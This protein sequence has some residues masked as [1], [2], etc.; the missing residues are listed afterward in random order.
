MPT[1]RQQIIDLLAEAEMTALDLSKALSIREK[2]VYDHLSHAAKSA[3][4]RGREFVVVPPRCLACGFT[5]DTRK[6]LTRPSRCPKCK[7][8]R[9]REPVFSI[10]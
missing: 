9:I 4:A 1:I 5:F 6:R 10:Q 7:E 3:S 8:Q 2:A